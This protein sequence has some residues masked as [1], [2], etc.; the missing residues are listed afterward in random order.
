MRVDPIDYVA[1]WRRLVQARNDQ[2]RR[3]DPQHGRA[4][5]WAGPRAARFR[6]M[7]VV[8][9][10]AGSDPFLD[11]VLPSVTKAT[12]VLDVGAGAGRHVITLAQAAA[13][14]VAV[15]P[16]PGMREQLAIGLTEAGLR[17]VEVVPEGWPEAK[18]AP[19]DIV[20][21]SHVAYFTEEIDPFLRRLKDVA[22]MRCYMVLRF[23]QRELAMLDLFEQVWGEPRSYEPTFADL[24]GAACQL[25]IYPNVTRIPYSVNV[26]FESLDEAVR[27]VRA[28]ILNPETEGVE[29][30]IRAYLN[31]R[32]IVRDGKWSWD[33]PPMWAGVLWWEGR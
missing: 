30:T 15:E 8:A 17:N 9:Q 12:T 27:T 32:M 13:Q 26:Q 25:G 28:D 11:L 16:S 21:C 10:N 3:V 19:A 5:H 20:I 33:L 29:E 24:F 18:V 23:Q 31:E 22:R 4:D 14:V 6:Q 7:T 1:R 2:G